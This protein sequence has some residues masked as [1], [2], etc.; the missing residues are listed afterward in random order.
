QALVQVVGAQPTAQEL[1]GRRRLGPRLVPA[2]HV[3]AVD[4]AVAREPDL[5]IPPPL[6]APDRRHAPVARAERVLDDRAGD[7]A[8]GV[9]LPADA[10]AVAAGLV[11]DRLGVGRVGHGAPG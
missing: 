4:L 8:A 11:D 2:R 7:L 10:A 5:A 6:V 9:G 3:P 1:V